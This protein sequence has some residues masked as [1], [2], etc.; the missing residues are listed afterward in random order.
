V[1]GVTGAFAPINTATNT[2]GSQVVS[3]GPFATFAAVALNGTGYAGWNSAG[4]RGRGVWAVN[5]TNGTVYNNAPIPAAGPADIAITLDGTTAYIVDSA[6]G[7][8]TPINTTTQVAGTPIPVGSDPGKMVITP[9][10]TTG[11]VILQSAHSV[12]PVNLATGAVGAAIPVG[13]TP[14]NMEIARDGAT[15]WVENQSAGTLLPISTTTDTAGTPIPVGDLTASSYDGAFAITPDGTTAYVLANGTNTTAPVLVR[16]NLTT[17][18]LSAGINVGAPPTDVAIT[19]DGTTAYVVN[20]GYP[21]SSVVPV[22]LAAN[23]AGTAIPVN[24]NQAQFIAFPS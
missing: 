16:V 21:T 3:T 18:T 2:A 10:G 14:G 13:G 11:Y 15:V 6:A 23:T 5:L 8:V 7:T 17:G 19:P 4:G 22:N 24:I 1:V 9:A 12:V 20:S